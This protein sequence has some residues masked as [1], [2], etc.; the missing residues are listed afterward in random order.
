MEVFPTRITRLIPS[1]ASSSRQMA[2]ETPMMFPV[3]TQEAVETIR[4]WKGD[5]PPSLGFTIRSR[6]ASGSMR[7]WTKPIRK[8]K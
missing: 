5:V 4:A 1:R 3:P 2:V 8:L 6:R 7:T